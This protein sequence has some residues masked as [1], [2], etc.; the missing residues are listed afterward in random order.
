MNGVTNGALDV[1]DHR[2]D[3]LGRSASEELVHTYMTIR[4]VLTLRFALCQSHLRLDPSL[5]RLAL[6]LI[7]RGASKNPANNNT[8]VSRLPPPSFLLSKLCRRNLGRMPSAIFR[9]GTK[10][11]RIAR[12]PS[13]GAFDRCV[14]YANVRGFYRK[15]RRRS[16]ARCKTEALLAIN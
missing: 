14:T 4:L 2:G 12:S 1:R 16:G 10:P 11:W 8:D 3:N 15:R 7:D 13:L 5:R 9:L 6:T